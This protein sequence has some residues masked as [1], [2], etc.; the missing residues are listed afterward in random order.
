MKV[1]PARADPINGSLST[2]KLN[3]LRLGGLRAAYLPLLILSGYSQEYGLSV[4]P[5]ECLVQSLGSL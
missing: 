1:F 3:E 5:V 4:F 2:V